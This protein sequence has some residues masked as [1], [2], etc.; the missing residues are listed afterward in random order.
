M[1]RWNDRNELSFVFVGHHLASWAFAL[2]GGLVARRCHPLR[3][4]T[5][6]Q[7]GRDDPP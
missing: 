6:M 2:T 4:Q 1:V 3:T 5:D 7:A